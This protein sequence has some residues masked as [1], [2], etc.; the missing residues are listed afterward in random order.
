M[1]SQPNSGHAFAQF[2]GIWSRRKRL[3]LV[4]FAIIAVPA[5][6]AVL[7][8]PDVYEAQATVIP[9]GNSLTQS[10][11]LGGGGGSELDAVTT[12]VLGRD[13]LADLIKRF[14]LFPGSKASAEQATEAMRKDIAIQT[15]QTQQTMNAQ[16]ISVNVSYRG[17][18]PKTVAAVTNALA[19]SYEKVALD[20]Q[21]QEATAAVATLKD[22]LDIVRA[23]LN[24]QQALIDRY[25]KEHP[26]ELLDQQAANLA[27]MQR[28]DGQLRDND[29]KQLQLMQ[30][31]N[32]L[33][34]QMQASGESDLTQLEQRLA[35]LKLSYTDQYPEVISIK[36]RIA[37]LKKREGNNPQSAEAQT[38]HEKELEGVD[39]DLSRLKSEEQKMQSRLA[40]Y[41][42]RLDDAPLAEQQLKTLTQ[43]YSET[44]DLYT[45]L[46]TSYEQAQVAH[47][48]SAQTG[49]QYRVLE[50]AMVPSA[51]AGPGRLR[52]LVMSLVLALGVAALAALIAEQRDTSFHSL[53]DVREFTSLEILATIP[54]I[55][56]TSDIRKRWVFL[57]VELLCVICLV[58]VLGTAAVTY[59]HTNH[60]L[61]QR[62]SHHATSSNS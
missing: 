52:L 49:Q 1:S 21:K 48:T 18:D 4:L 10:S 47:A 6:C 57:G 27:A 60:S 36:A 12:Q 34:Q 2:A 23:K 43:G 5:V 15:Q 45:S 38:P 33:L 11:N 25:R 53:E 50:S 35:D 55:S 20:I 30:R 29:S 46:L 61:A 62:L 26:G 41:Q 9:V 14:D 51:A 32:S 39:S 7:A 54:L 8:L 44:N 59:T 28:L 22:R 37:A 40:L 31:R 3:V 19:A 58:G 16:P 17:S 56:T 13:R 42:R 24:K